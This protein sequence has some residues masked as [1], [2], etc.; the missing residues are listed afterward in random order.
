MAMARAARRAGRVD[1]HPEAL[2]AAVELTAPD[3]GKRCMPLADLYRLPGKTP[4]IETVM[5]PG[6]LITTGSVSSG[7]IARKSCYL[8]VRDRTSF[9]FPLV[10]AAAGLDVA[11]RSIRDARVAFG[12]VAPMPWR[13]TKG[14]AA[15]R[16][17]RPRRA[18]LERVAALAGEGAA[19][20][21]GNDYEIEL[22][23]RAVPHA[24]QTVADRESL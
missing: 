14:K 21:G 19:A 17:Q 12:G 18:V 15:L 7:P 11:D 9:Q 22:T 2:D 8:K 10:S 24:L 6:E 5:R 3:G 1:R 16:G 20:A 13:L 4:H 23:R